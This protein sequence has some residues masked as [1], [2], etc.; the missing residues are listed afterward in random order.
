VTPACKGGGSTRLTCRSP[1]QLSGPVAEGPDLPGEGGLNP[2][3]WPPM[4]F[5]LTN[6]LAFLRVLLT[7]LDSC[8]AA[9]GQRASDP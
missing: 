7:A 3:T 8:T 2:V 4:E 9:P 1:G 6:C 5:G